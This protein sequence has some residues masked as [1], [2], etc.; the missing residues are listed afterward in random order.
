MKRQRKGGYLISKIHRMSGRI[1]SKILKQN[2]LDEI[3]TAQ[4]RILF[5]LWQEDGISIVKLA[6][7]TALSKSTLT[8]ML[9]RLEEAGYV[10]RV[11]SKTDRR[12][13]Q[14]YLTTEGDK[15][16]ENYLGVSKKM[17]ELFY[18]GFTDTEITEFEVYLERILENL[19][20]HS[21]N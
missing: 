12:K 4:G 9:D 19:K 3:N 2:E 6:K 14:I 15:L 5:P 17:T 18:E 8:S 11:S 1:F 10:R 13:M 16:Q 21:L 7:E 20:K